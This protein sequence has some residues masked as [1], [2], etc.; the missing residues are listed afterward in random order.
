MSLDLAPIRFRGETTPAS[1]F[2]TI[3]AGVGSEAPRTH[4]V[5]II[6]HLHND[7]MSVRGTFAERHVDVEETDHLCEHRDDVAPPT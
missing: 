3:R 4:E 1:E 2:G 7:R 6:E 5:A